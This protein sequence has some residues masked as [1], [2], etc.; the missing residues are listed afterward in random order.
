MGVDGV[1][2]EMLEKPTKVTT[3]RSQNDAKNGQTHPLH[4]F[5]ATQMCKLY[6]SCVS[7]M[8]EHNPKWQPNEWTQVKPMPEH[9]NKEQKEQ[10]S[11][12]IVF[13]GK[14]QVY[15]AIHRLARDSGEPM[16]LMPNFDYGD[17]LNF[18]RF[19][20]ALK[21][22]GI[23]AISK[24]K[25][26]LNNKDMHKME[27]D[28]VVI[29]PI[30]GVLLFEVKECDHLDAKRRSRARIQLNNA[31][32]CFR[33]MGRL[34]FEAKGWTSTEAS[35]PMVECIALPNQEERPESPS[36]KTALNQSLN[37]STVSTHSPRHS[38]TLHYLIKSDL[39]SYS[40]FAK[41][42]KLNVVEPKLQKDAEWAEQSKVNKFDSSAINWMTGLISCIRNNSIMPIVCSEAGTPVDMSPLKVEEV[43]QTEQS[44]EP[45]TEANLEKEKAEKESEK[46]RERLKEDERR[47]NMPA[48]NINGE[49]FS[50]EHEA[51]RSL[52]KVIVTSRNVE[53]MRK[54][55][56]KQILWML[57]NDHQKKISVVCSEMNKPYYEE[58]FMRQ[59]KI[60]NNCTNVRFY[61]TLESCTVDGQHSTLKK[62]V[63]TWFFDSCL[64][65]P[66]ENVVEKARELS[67]FWL[68]TNE[69]EKLMSQWKSDMESL[70]VKIVKLDGADEVSQMQTM[71]LMNEASFK[72]P[73]RLQ[74]DV[75]VIG[76]IIGT[77][78]LKSLYRLM[79][80]NNV[81][82]LSTMYS[83]DGHESTHNNHSRHHNNQHPSQQLAFNPSKKFKTI[84][85]IRGGSIEN[86]RNSL[87]MHDSIQA[88]V[89]LM[90]VGDEDLFKSRSSSCTTDRV[91]ELSTLVKEYCPKSFVILSTLMRRLSRTENTASAEVN[92]GIKEFCKETK[93]TL[94]LHYMLNSHFDP[95]YHT[96]EGRA[97]NNKGL[98]RYVD[99]FL[100]FVD[101]FMVR[102]HK[103]H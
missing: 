66:L 26:Y 48:L 35:V 78:H 25:Q 101:H 13:S 46:E 102:N 91:K 17:I 59:R 62:D 20:Q 49:F 31:T 87:K 3:Q 16:I 50:R 70:K 19:L 85:F 83:K 56:C 72:L 60:Y 22:D 100:W 2:S 41:W 69:E 47:R 39:S 79:T 45:K 80:N 15:D 84:K 9:L 37:Q 75:L 18:E 86:I 30:Y 43:K 38:R 57:L 27:I 88:Q 54:T 11:N 4:Q 52:T 68:F 23:N 29:H 6:Q 74:C 58:F 92:K 89:I 55:I 21:V 76:D 99:N 32:N 24:Y 94:N 82:N 73:L 97:L 5:D 12:P 51:V 95:D 34:V 98:Q 10:W 28:L 77:V 90:H 8:H 63:E 44:S 53:K 71:S 67:A 36:D 61:T 96:Q 40:E 81:P 7:K 93:Q 1:K 103:Q 64:N 14:Q 33:S 65:K 42:W